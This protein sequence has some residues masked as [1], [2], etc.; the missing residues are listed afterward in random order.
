MVFI[1]CNPESHQKAKWISKSR[2]LET[3]IF[4]KSYETEKQK[5]CSKMTCLPN[6]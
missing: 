2:E 1:T 6:K 4:L 5:L 3:V